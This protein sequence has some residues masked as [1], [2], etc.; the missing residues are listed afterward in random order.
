MSY[1]NNSNCVCRNR[2]GNNVESNV[3]RRR[4]DCVYECLLELLEDAGENNNNNNHHCCCCNR[5]R[6]DVRP[7]GGS[8][9]RCNCECVYECLYD[10]LDDALEEEDDFCKC[11]R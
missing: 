9:R 1:R 3:V 2:C 5:V 11:P 4:C 6:P 10:L 8:N 7:G